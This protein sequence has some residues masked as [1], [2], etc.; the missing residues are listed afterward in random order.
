MQLEQRRLGALDPSAVTTDENG[1][2]EITVTGHLVDW[3]VWALLA[4]LLLTSFDLT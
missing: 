2:E 4:G 1:M 3:Y